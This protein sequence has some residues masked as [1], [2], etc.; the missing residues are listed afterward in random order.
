MT[1]IHDRTFLI[2]GKEALI[3]FFCMKPDHRAAQNGTI[4]DHLTVT[5]GVWAYCAKDAR[6]A[7]HVWEPTGGIA[8]N[9]VERFARSRDARDMRDPGDP[10]QKP[11]D[12]KAREAHR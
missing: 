1:A 9:E 6:L 12:R 7:D 3:A 2:V 10:R 4:S 5:E 8:M 11:D